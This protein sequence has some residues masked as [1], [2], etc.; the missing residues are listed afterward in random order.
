MK[1]PPAPSFPRPSLRTTTS[2]KSRPALLHCCLSLRVAT[3]TTTTTVPS[4]RNLRVASAA[5]R[6]KE[7]T[8]VVVVASGKA[9]VHVVQNPER[10]YRGA[11]GGKE[12]GRDGVGMRT[13]VRTD[14][15]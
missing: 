1:S 14:E 8:D 4:Q 10:A 2:S 9:Q 7:L 12:K 3:A 6:V 13:L 15:A 5:E 11:L